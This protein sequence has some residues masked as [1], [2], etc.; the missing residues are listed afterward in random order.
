M[1][2]P[3]V[4][5]LACMTNRAL[6]GRYTRLCRLEAQARRTGNDHKLAEVSEAFST[7]ME[8]AEKYNLPVEP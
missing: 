4:E 6:K 1:K 2:N 3:S 5:Q 8:A 7:L